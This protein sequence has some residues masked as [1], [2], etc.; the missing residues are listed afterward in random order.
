MFRSQKFS[1]VMSCPDQSADATKKISKTHHPTWTYDLRIDPKTKLR[2]SEDLSYLGPNVKTILTTYIHALNYDSLRFLGPDG[3]AY[4][5]V[6]STKLSSINGSR[7]DTLRHAL[8][9]SVGH[10]PDPLY[11]HIVAD[12]CFWDGHVDSTGSARL[13][14]EALYIRSQS[15]DPALVVA[16][17]QIVKDWEKNTLREEKRNN[18]RAFQISENEARECE[19]GRMSYWRGDERDNKG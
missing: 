6:S 10:N 16:T 9:V 13:P 15:V 3:R 12:H 18:P 1:W 8:F 5:W 14:D 4:I 17:L 11:G 19:L 7:Y 2:V